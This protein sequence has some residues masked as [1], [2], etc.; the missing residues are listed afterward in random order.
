[1]LKEIDVQRIIRLIKYL[2]YTQIT[3]LEQFQTVSRIHGKIYTFKCRTQ[4]LV[5]S[6]ID[7]NRS[8]KRQK[9]LQA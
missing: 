2:K 5:K 8:D 9:H 3:V 1:V 4:L 6:L 7:F